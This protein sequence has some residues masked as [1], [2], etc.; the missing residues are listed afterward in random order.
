M[1]DFY[2]RW[3]RAII[4]NFGTLSKKMIHYGMSKNHISVSPQFLTN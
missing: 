4:G 3:R 2:S 1:V